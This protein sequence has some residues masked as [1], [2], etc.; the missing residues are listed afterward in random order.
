M[1][2]LLQ[3]Q[4]GNIYFTELPE[5]VEYGNYVAIIRPPPRGRAGGMPPSDEHSMT[6]YTHVYI[7]AYMH[8][9]IYIMYIYI[10]IYICR[11]TPTSETIQTIHVQALCRALI[12]DDLACQ[13]SLVLMNV[14]TS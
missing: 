2:L 1:W 3:A 5:R 12:C 11:G 10:Y 6:L 14:E 9:Y 13:D 7:D 4:K 8:I